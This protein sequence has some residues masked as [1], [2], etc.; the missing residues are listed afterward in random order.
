MKNILYGLIF[1]SWS[2]VVDAATV[3][4]IGPTLEVTIERKSEKLPLSK[5]DKLVAGDKFYASPIN[6]SLSKEDWILI[7]AQI[8]PFGNNVKISKFNLTNLK[9]KPFVEIQNEDD[10]L[11]IVLAPQLRTFFGLTRS[12]SGSADTI[13]EIINSDPQKF[14]ELQKLDLF[15]K[16]IQIINQSIENAGTSPNGNQVIQAV[17]QTAI[18]YGV[19]NI[20]LECFKENTVNLECA[21]SSF[22]SNIDFSAKDS[23][24]LDNQD[25]AKKSFENLGFLGANIRLITDAGNFLTDKFRDRYTFSPA[26]SIPKND[27]NTLQLYSLS[28]FKSGEI[29]T[30][31]AFAPSWQKISPPIL[32][33]KRDI[34]CI[35]QGS[36]EVS[37]LGQLPIGDYWHSWN[38]SFFDKE[39]NELIGSTNK[40]KFNQEE[41]LFT[42]AVPDVAKFYEHELSNYEAR[43]V[44]KY[45]FQDI[46]ISPIEVNIAKTYFSKTDFLKLNDLISKE[47]GSISLKDASKNNCI[48]SLELEKD[49]HIIA[50][51]NPTNP[52]EFQFNLSEISPGP[53]KIIISQYG[54]TKNVIDV[55]ILPPKSKI[56]SIEHVE[57]D[58]HITASGTDLDR[59]D[60]IKWGEIICKPETHMNI[61]SHSE[62]YIFDCGEEVKRHLK[63]PDTIT[64]F[65]KNNSPVSLRISIKKIDSH[66]QISLAENNKNAVLITPSVKA[67]QW[68]LTSSDKL[69]A[70]DSGLHLLL[71]A[72]N[73]YS[74]AKSSFQLQIRIKDD[75]ES[76]KRLI[77]APLIS[78]AAKGELRTRNPIYFKDIDFPSVIN[79]LEFR[80]IQQQTGLASRWTE[81]KWS[82]ITIP[83]IKSVTCQPESKV[84]HIHGSQLEIIDGIYSYSTGNNPSNDNALLL[85]SNT[86]IENCDD[87]LCLRL[88]APPKEGLMLIKL[89]WAENFLFKVKIFDDLTGCE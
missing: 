84:V 85:D 78:D 67:I 38:I 47:K 7:I 75:P 60:F 32:A 46:S 35:S 69:L 2:A 55:F 80:V 23:K 53:A 21:A 56:T 26:F 42:F 58:R 77:K 72:K 11:V 76:E 68:G 28:R 29:K 17:K 52:T 54:S 45:G 87:G 4:H 5:V 73:G 88:N 24:E 16:A 44:G 36:I 63:L 40:I 19:K 61:G 43:I 57:F 25:R 3:T 74:L 15:N 50:K 6:S 65:H 83:N 27:S 49:D 71:V 82:V 14:F 33:S 13:D 70:E 18:K 31:Y 89:R 8:S 62:N 9:E 41:G 37:T 51:S 64:V 79:P 86:P 59:I 81:L 1:L 22:V 48:K 39:K 66:P 10:S 30:A 12:F 34:P 20:N